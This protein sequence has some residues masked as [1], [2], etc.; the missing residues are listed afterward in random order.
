MP[1]INSVHYGISQY[2][3][4]ID[5]H[6][7]YSTFPYILCPITAATY[8]FEWE[9]VTTQQY[10][11]I[12]QSINHVFCYSWLC[13]EPVDKWDLLGNMWWSGNSN[14]D[15]NQWRSIPWGWKVH[16]RSLRDYSLHCN[17]HAMS[18]Y[19]N[20]IVSLY[21]MSMSDCVLKDQIWE[22]LYSVFL[23]VSLQSSFNK[24]LVV[25][26]LIVFWAIGLTEPVRQH[27]MGQAS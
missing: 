22:L 13:L 26:Q 24:E 27:V 3:I 5:I 18:R 12:A 9:F 8:Q 19:A 10:C 15:Q 2:H 14:E 4:F 25:L 20:W 6:W 16:R 17:G 21:S 7:G 1:H 23:Y 11:F